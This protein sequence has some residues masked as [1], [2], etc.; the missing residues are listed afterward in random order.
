M[1]FY[2]SA[3]Y[4]D[5]TPILGNLD[6]Q[7]SWEGKNYKRT[8]WYKRLPNHKTLNNKVYKYHIADESGRTLEVVMNQTYQES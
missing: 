2:V 3:F 6:G 4:R 7:R 5:G 1:R 8:T